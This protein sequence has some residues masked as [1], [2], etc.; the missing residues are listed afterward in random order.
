MVARKDHGR[1]AFESLPSY[2]NKRGWELRRVEGRHAFEVKT[3]RGRFTTTLLFEIEIELTQFMFYIF[4][5][6]KLFDYMLPR[7]AEYVCRANVELLIGNFELDFDDPEFCFSF[8]NSIDFRE[9]RLTPQLMDGVIESAFTAF[10]KFFPTGLMRVI[11]DLDTP[12][13]AI[14]KIKCGEI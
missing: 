8:K 12:A 13:E 10:D 3:K 6:V 11:V 4:P 7:V 14:R 2:L 9:A 5:P 1:V